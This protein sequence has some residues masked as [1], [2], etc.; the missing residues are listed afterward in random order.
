M[1]TLSKI[2]TTGLTGHLP[3]APVTPQERRAVVFTAGVWLVFLA[4]TVIGFINSTAP[5]SAQLAGWLALVAFPF[6]YLQAFVKPE[7]LPRLNRAGNTMGYTLVL[8]GLGVIMALAAPTAII[9]IVPYLMAIWVFNHRLITGII[10]IV[11]I[12]GAAVIVVALGQLD[13]Y[14]NWFI[15]SVASPAI[16]MIFIRISIEL[17][18]NQRERS[19]QLALA[20]RTVHAGGRAV[21]PVLAAES[22]SAGANPLTD[23]ER[24]ALREA[25]SGASVKHI[26]ARLNLSAGT[27]RNHLSSEIGKTQTSNRTEAA[28]YAHQNGWL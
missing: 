21:D 10:A 11:V 25:L 22:L 17:G 24:D 19:E 8:V 28:R 2:T 23:R 16:I 1:S 7:P 26:A 4:W 6:I 27:V 5:V 20:I 3:D 14:G 18:V 15:A 12:F 13:D 9:N